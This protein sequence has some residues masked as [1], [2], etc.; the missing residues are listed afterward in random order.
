[1][2]LKLFVLAGALWLFSPP[3]AAD[4]HLSRRG[5]GSVVI[6]ND[7]VGSGWRVAGRAP[8]DEYLVWR[9]NAPSPY[10]ADIKSTA[11]R[12]GVD[13]SLVKSV[14]LVESNFN[15]KAVSRKGARG[16][17]QLMPGTAGRYGV[18]HLHAAAENIRGGVR[19]LAD[20]LSMF[21][22]DAALAVA[23]YNSGENAVLRYDGIPPYPETQEYVRRV[24]VAYGTVPPAPMSA[25]PALGGGF[26]GVP[27]ASRP[28]RVAD[29]NGTRLLENDGVPQREA[30]LL[31]RVR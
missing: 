25:R 1:M 17:M 7:S 15:P 23:A 8:T 10:D 27:P 18:E 11:S 6:F 9:R 13:P 2:T 22:G 19:Y 3:A 12:H 28:V 20:L 29:W 16:L 26:R 4:V 30:P 5:D 31:G 21:R 24:M 14:M